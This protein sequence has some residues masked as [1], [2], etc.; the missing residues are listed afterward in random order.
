ME[1]HLFQVHLDQRSDETNPT[2]IL[3]GET[4]PKKCLPN[5][6]CPPER[7]ALARNFLAWISIPRLRSPIWAAPIIFSAVADALAWAMLCS[8]IPVLLHYLDDFLVWAADYTT[9]LSHL[10]NA[11]AIASKLGLPVEPTKVESPAHS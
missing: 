11:I 2:G 8:G 7:P 5:D 10:N 3:H 4:R 9:C 1:F 6:T